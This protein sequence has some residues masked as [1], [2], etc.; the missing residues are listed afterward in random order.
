MT[1]RP[2][3]LSIGL[4]GAIATAAGGQSPKGVS[5]P[6]VAEQ[7]MAASRAITSIGPDPCRT[8]ATDEEIVVC[9]RR[10]SPYALP[11]YEPVVR[12]DGPTGRQR[13]DAVGTMRDTAA[14]C[15][16]RG[17]ACLKPLPLIG[18]PVGAGKKGGVR[19]GKQ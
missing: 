1:N 4:G 8:V 7:V 15:H 9:G 16:A 14:G 17:E 12:D 13:E 2:L 10:E 19:I 11:L 5:K 18:I 3:L 6:I